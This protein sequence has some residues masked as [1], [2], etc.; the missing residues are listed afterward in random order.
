MNSFFWLVAYVYVFY[1]LFIVAMAAKHAWS[2]LPIAVK[3]ILAPVAVVAITMDVVFNIAVATFLLWDLPKEWTFTQRL[4]RYESSSG[5]RSAT[6]FWI[7]RNML[8]VFEV[9]GHCRG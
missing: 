6:A 7:C 2:S 1:L 8:D 5:W 9:G 4:S 3:V